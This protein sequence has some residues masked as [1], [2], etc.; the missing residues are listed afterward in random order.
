MRIQI[1]NAD[2]RCFGDRNYKRFRNI[3]NNEII[4]LEVQNDITIKDLNEKY[5]NKGGSGCFYTFNENY[6]RHDRTLS[7]YGIKDGNTIECTGIIGG[8]D[9]Y[10]KSQNTHIC[11]NG[12]KR[13]IPDKYKDCDEW[14][15]ACPYD[16]KSK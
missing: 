11:P 16:F 12:C 6:L 5:H 2:Y 7:Y 8:G 9:P 10:I 15:S 4:E 14:M 13:Y 1:R 3:E